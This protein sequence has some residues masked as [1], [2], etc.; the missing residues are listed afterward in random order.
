MGCLKIKVK[1]VRRATRHR[2]YNRIF[3]ESWPQKAAPGTPDSGPARAA[4]AAYVRFD[5]EFFEGEVHSG[6]FFEGTSLG[7]GAIFKPAATTT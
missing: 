6:K 5:D 7:F 2:F 4:W 1:V 3:S